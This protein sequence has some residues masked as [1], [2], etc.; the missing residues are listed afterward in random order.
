MYKRVLLLLLSSSL[1]LAACVETKPIEQLAIINARGVDLIQQKDEQLIDTTLVIFQFDTQTKDISK[2]ASGTGK[3]IKEAG[4]NANEKTSFTLTSGQ[5]RLELY[6]IETAKTGVMQYLNTLA[7]DAR[8][9]DRVMLAVTDKTAKEVLTNGQ[10]ATSINVGLFINGL[11]KQKVE[12]DSIPKVEFNDFTHAYFESGRDPVL[13][14]ISV[15]DGDVPSL[16]KIAL[17]QDDV[18][19]GTLSLKEALYINL[20]LKNI[21]STPFNIGIPIEQSLQDYLQEELSG[22]EKDHLYVN[23]K[24]I[25]GKSKTRLTRRETLKFK[26]DI[27]IQMNILELSNEL[28]LENDDVIK[29]LEKEIANQIKKEYERLLQKTQEMGADPFGYGQ[30]YRIHTPDGKLKKGEWHKLYPDIEVDYNIHVN[31]VDYGAV[32]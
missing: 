28:A 27:K 30:I 22:N 12:N 1:V 17:L 24:I 3:T 16:S 10:N 29:A 15:A 21:K 23:G 26:T 14:L 5:I 20:I 8:T 19:T 7:R 11:I 31:I 18:Y 2:I 6:G 32:R 4:Q 9:S 25:K 13:P